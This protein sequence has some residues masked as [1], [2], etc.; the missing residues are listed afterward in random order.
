MGSDVT[1]E[2]IKQQI[3]KR[4]KA[5]GSRQIQM[6]EAGQDPKD[7]DLE[8]LMPSKKGKG[9]QKFYLHHVSFERHIGTSQHILSHD[10]MKLWLIHTRNGQIHGR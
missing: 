9:C 5:L 2:A 4:I 8:D 10:N 1:I 3:S 6:R 7:V